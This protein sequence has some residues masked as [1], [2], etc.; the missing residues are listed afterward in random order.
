MEQKTYRLY[1]SAPL[2][3]NIDI[4]R[5]LEKNLNDRN[6]FNNS[7]NI[8]KEMITY[9]KDKNSKTK[10]KYKNYRTLYKVLESVDSFIVTGARYKF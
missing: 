6:S 10:N 5:R 4:E 3:K 8:I 1:S 2:E 7:I 9:F